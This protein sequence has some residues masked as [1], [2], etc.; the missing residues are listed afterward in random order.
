MVKLIISDSTTTGSQD[1]DGDYSSINRRKDTSN[2]FD[3][4][5]KCES[6]GEY[7]PTVLYK[8]I[9]WCVIISV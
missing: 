3:N 8:F 1:N 2:N 7:E 6:D 9:S 5:L 4:S